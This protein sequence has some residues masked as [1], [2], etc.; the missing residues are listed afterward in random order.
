MSIVGNKD[1]LADLSGDINA[2]LCTLV[3]LSKVE[4]AYVANTVRALDNSRHKKQSN[5]EV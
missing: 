4:S 1:C 3:K 2:Q 5:T